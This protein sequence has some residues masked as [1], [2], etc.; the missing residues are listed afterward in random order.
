V[1][2]ARLTGTAGDFYYSPAMVFPSPRLG[3]V[4]GGGVLD[5][6]RDG[7]AHWVRVRLGGAVRA[8][9]QF[10]SSLWA[11]VAPC[12]TATGRCRYRLETTTLAGASWH[13]A[14]PLPAA[15]GSYTPL[16]VTR[17]SMLRA[18]VALGQMT[19]APACLTT[20]GGA[21]WAPVRS[22]AP[23]GYSPIALAAA[24]P[25]G[26]LG[27]VP[28]RRSGSAGSSAKSLLRSTDAGQTW[29]VVAQ[30]RSLLPGAPHPVPTDEGDVLAVPSDKDRWFAGV[31]A[32]WGST[33]GGT[34]NAPQV[35][36]AI[37][38]LVITLF[39]LQGVTKITAETRRNA[40]N[41]RRPLQLLA[42]RPG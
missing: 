11:F 3:W 12:A 42:L 40:Q 20:G 4:A 5:V 30:D 19:S 29:T 36:S 8:V 32:L 23:P 1:V 25:A 17:L 24:G 14:G 10:G 38:N 2:G 34:G 16:V 22:C 21:Q 15:L 7:G 26:R 9:S 28:R 6:T 35:M 37:T 13:D 39:R 41:P 27:A 33:D 31:N 18:L